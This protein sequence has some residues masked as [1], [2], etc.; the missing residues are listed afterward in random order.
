MG[1]KPKAKKMALGDFLATTGGSTSWAD[2]T[3]NLPTEPS[4]RYVD[5]HD[6]RPAG[7][8]G[9]AFS[10]MG[11]G[12]QS[13]DR[14]GG[15]SGGRDYGSRSSTRE[16]SGPAE[17][18]DR[19]PYKAYVG[20]LDYAVDETA[21]RDFF[22]GCKVV[23]FYDVKD[24]ESGKPKGFG[25]VEFGDRESLVKAL[26]FNGQ[27]LMGR[28]VRIDVSES[29]GGD[30]PQRDRGGFGDSERGEEDRSAGGNWRE[31]AAP[32]PP[33]PAPSSRDRGF[34][35]DR[36]GDSSRSGGGFAD[37]YNDRSSDRFGDRSGDRYGDRDSSRSSAGRWGRSEAAPSEPAPAERPRLNLKPR[38][39]PVEKVEPKTAAEGAE[40]AKPAA[41]K[42]AAAEHK[43]EH[44]DH[45][46]S[47][48]FG[49]ARPV[50]TAQREAAIEKRLAEMR[51]KAAS[52]EP[53]SGEGKPADSH[54]GPREQASEPHE[55]RFSRDA[56]RP[57]HDD[58]GDRAGQYSHFGGG[59][60]DR[61]QRH[62]EHGSGYDRRDDRSGYGGERRDYGDRRD[63]RDSR[64]GDR[65]GHNRYP[66]GE[67]DRRGGYGN[68]GSGSYNR[69]DRRGP[70]G[71][72]QRA[73][74]REA[75]P[76][77]RGTPPPVAPISN[78]YAGLEADE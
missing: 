56:D 6:D 76:T 7:G 9:G 59:R 75:E 65:G 68:R 46:A 63:N 4:S 14:Y 47:N 72:E 12:S 36:Y 69:D 49:A 77:G 20:N 22:E 2:E 17:I 43:E 16:R 71:P 34:G 26:T 48:P 39:A 13:D 19:P 40:A 50:D 31:R 3:E 24:R 35:G 21:V 57:R 25:Y 33:A 52:K 51:L 70:S 15:S 38:T 1:P 64:G 29:K 74:P 10:R 66:R 45:K 37:R 32:L 58:G 78:K 55:R 18:P 41:E 27:D 23:S 30:R 67:D 5:D 54:D 53:A 60:R 44:H 8:I 42:A 73:P 11:Y 28:N 62:A 61:E